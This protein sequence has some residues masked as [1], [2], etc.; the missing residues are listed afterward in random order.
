MTSSSRLSS[1]LGGLKS[2]GT[3]SDSPGTRSDPSARPKKRPNPEQEA[4]LASRADKL[5]IK[6]YAGCGKTSLLRLFARQASKGR[7]LYLAFNKPIAL[8][9]QEMFGDTAVCQTSH[10]LA[11]RAL[12]RVDS[13]WRNT[14]L[15]EK[16]GQPSPARFA[17]ALRGTITS[18]EVS[19]GVPKICLDAIRSFLASSNSEIG[20]Q[21]LF[22]ADPIAG[23][24]AKRLSFDPS[25]LVFLAKAAW[26]KMSNPAD[27]SLQL[28]HDGYLKL[29]SLAEIPI[30]ADLILIDE[31]QDSNPALLS[32]LRGQ[33][34]RQIYVGDEHQAIYGFR[35]ALNAFSALDGA[36]THYLT[37]SFRLKSKISRLASGVLLIKDAEKPLIGHGEGGLIDRRPPL[38]AQSLFLA[39]S[40]PGLFEKAL[41]LAKK[42]KR[43][44][45]LN[46]DSSRFS[47]SGIDDLLA[48]RAGREP[49]DPMLKVFQSFDIL[50]EAAEESMDADLL[51]KLRLVEEYG[52]SLPEA[53]ASISRHSVSTPEAAS[54]TLSTV[55]KAKGL[56]A[57][58]CELADDFELSSFQQDK[59]DFID[60][61]ETEEANIFYVAITRAKEGLALSP[62]Q[63]KWAQKIEKLFA[64]PAKHPVSP[65]MRT[66]AEAFLLQESVGDSAASGQGGRQRSFL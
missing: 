28:P 38:G 32:A 20:P 59:I 22:N 30:D 33:S 61:K 62:R 11:L 15:G 42:G 47:I 63:L 34:S 19:A 18:A 6:A 52:P 40:N 24:A 35:G 58:W 29:W 25:R 55:H 36:E 13:R 17:D 26:S 56:E 8:S 1:A 21:H 3:A 16:I 7:T 10:S 41:S 49:S 53:L 37:R 57:D 43:M 48:L 45:F 46:G 2:L 60:P 65:E 31:A 39:R 51:I 5:Q 50:K 27:L 64:S 66:K 12:M 23:S 54:C 9:A 44:Y 14:P 4:A